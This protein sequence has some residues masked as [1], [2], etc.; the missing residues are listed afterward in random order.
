[1]RSLPV[2][3]NS[4]FGW[5]LAATFLMP[6]AVGCDKQTIFTPV[7]LLSSRAA[8]AGAF[9]VLSECFFQWPYLYGAILSLW[10]SATA[11]VRPRRLGSWLLPL[12][13]SFLV[14]ITLGGAV[15]VH[16]TNAWDECLVVTLLFLLPQITVLIW[17]AF[18]MRKDHLLAATRGISGL[19]AIATVAIY[20]H[21][22]TIFASRF[23]YGFYV[24]MG[25]TIGLT[26]SAW[27]LYSRGEQSLC[28]RSLPKRPIQFRIKTMLLWTTFVAIIAAIYQLLARQE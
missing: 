15:A 9:G 7:T 22:V 11:I 16:F 8:E 17:L 5:I 4:L 25:A 20:L 28:D 27:L 12:P 10:L 14:P 24:A 19:G 18:G 13:V 3:S 23:L 1:M 6:F 21:A 2:E 26:F